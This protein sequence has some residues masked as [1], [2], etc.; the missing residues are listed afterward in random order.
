MIFAS[1]MLISFIKPNRHETRLAQRQYFTL[2]QESLLLQVHLAFLYVARRHALG[3]NV[4]CL[5][6]IEVERLPNCVV[7]LRV[8]VPSLEVEEE[9]QGLVAAFGKQA[10]IPGYR[11]G[12]A[13]A[14]IIERQYEKEIQEELAR[15]LLSE[16]VR[17]ARVE[18]QVE[19]LRVLN[20]E[21]AELT[22]KED[23]RPI[24]TVSVP[25]E[26]KIEPSAYQGLEI[27]IPAF[28]PTNEELEEMVQSFQERNSRYE[29]IIDRPLAIGDFAVLELFGTK[30]GSPLSDIYPDLPPNIV[31]AD[32]L[33][34][35]CNTTAFLPGFGEAIQGLQIG[36][37]REFDL[38][39]PSDFPIEQL[40]E[41][42]LH[43][44][45]TLKGIK[46]KVLPE[47]TDEL[48]V[49]SGF[50]SVDDLR[51]SAE[52]Y[53][54]A[55]RLSESRKQKTQLI[56]E[57]LAGLVNTDLPMDEVQF[58]TRRMVD[59]IVKTNSQRGVP[60]DLLKEK[61]EEIVS[62]A[63]KAAQKRVRTD[64]VL[65]HIAKE[66]GFSVTRA[67][68]DAS[69]RQ[70]AEYQKEPFAKVRKKIEENGGLKPLERSILEQKALQ[71]VENL[72]VV[73]Y[74][75]PDGSVVA[76]E[77]YVAQL[78]IK[79]PGS[80][81]E[82]VD[83]DEDDNLILD[84]AASTEDDYEFQEGDELPSPAVASAVELQDAAAEIQA[85]IKLDH[86]SNPVDPDAKA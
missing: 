49:E 37:T 82:E 39:V 18:H 75:M 28:E 19:Y 45:T 2:L 64:F 44:K 56:H 79:Y 21:E 47:L 50:K 30:D 7:A 15:R 70:Y 32:D 77:E 66:Q 1:P 69:I 16:A 74:E 5:M 68:L 31:Q 29:D 40:R 38:T 33:W 59:D 71:H 76:E 52:R 57:Q 78:D 34:V 72:A 11:P 85:D 8:H 43:Y 60:E 48:A 14:K 41:Q 54:I 84:Q 13:P 26:I 86:A 53:L 10:R 67:E 62:T 3:M 20:L 35:P 46:D 27:K 55:N 80:P 25:P 24:I 23:Y 83:P 65:Q 6:N 61:E 51:K 17:Q 58:E 42:T 12:K 63:A 9:R 73:R 81:L 36:E 4:G 22:P